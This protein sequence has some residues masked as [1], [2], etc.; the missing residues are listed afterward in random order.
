M[1]FQVCRSF[2]IAALLFLLSFPSFA[3]EEPQ[4]TITVSGSKT[5]YLI[6]WIGP[7]V[8]DYITSMD[9]KKIK[10]IH[11]F[12]KGGKLKQALAIA[13]FIKKNN[14][15]TYVGIQ[16]KC[17]SACTIV[18]QAGSKRTAH[19]SAKFMYH[20][21][22]TREGSNKEIMI[23]SEYWTEIMRNMLVQYGALK[24][25]GDLIRSNKDLYLTAEEAM[26][27]GIVTTVED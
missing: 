10:R 2:K 1:L 14:I 22:Y 21:V 19:K 23:D 26:I 6:G 9:P 11:L 5:V 12:S 20:Y 16:G 25:L 18:F 8:A 27:Y 3:F 17:Y 13:E 7:G 15:E 24:E 4:E